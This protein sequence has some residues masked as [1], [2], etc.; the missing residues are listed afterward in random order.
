MEPGQSEDLSEEGIRLQVTL[1]CL[2]LRV[3]GVVL[4]FVLKPQEAWIPGPSSLD[5]SSLLG[6]RNLRPGLSRLTLKI[7]FSICLM[8]PVFNSLWCKQVHHKRA[9][10][11]RKRDTVL[12]P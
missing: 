6:C 4:K 3:V 1:P 11:P 7:L 8:T 5:L 2:P 9:T 12:S 10:L